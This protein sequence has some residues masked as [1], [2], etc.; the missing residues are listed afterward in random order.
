[1]QVDYHKFGI[2]VR[3]YEQSGYPSN[4]YQ[5]YD[6]WETFLVDKQIQRITWL[7]QNLPFRLFWALSL[8]SL[9]SVRE[10]LQVCLIHMREV[11]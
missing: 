2:K 8:F 7:L 1:M 5:Y 9:N 3:L 10:L 11:L 4:F 6:R